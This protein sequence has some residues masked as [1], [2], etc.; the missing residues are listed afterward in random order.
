MSFKVKFLGL[1][2]RLIFFCFIDLNFHISVFFF[3]EKG[4]S[5]K[6]HKGNTKVY[7]LSRQL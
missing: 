6:M 3:F 2:F 7:T 5:I 4:L 1:D